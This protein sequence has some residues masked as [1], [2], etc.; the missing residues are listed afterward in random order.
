METEI[1]VG[2]ECKVKQGRRETSTGKIATI[3]KH[4]VSYTVEAI[5]ILVSGHLLTNP[6]SDQTVTNHGR[7]CSSSYIMTVPFCE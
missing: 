5:Y 7:L 2:G 1:E 6:A 3:S 4:T